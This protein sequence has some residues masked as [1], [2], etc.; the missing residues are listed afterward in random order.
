[1]SGPFQDLANWYWL[2]TP[3][4]YGSPILYSTASNGLVSLTNATYLAWVAAGGTANPW[5]PIGAPTT[6]GL[7][8]LLES[9]GLPATGLTVPTQAQLTA[10]IPSVVSGYLAAQRGYAYTFNIASATYNSTTG[11]LSLTF[12]VA[13]L[14]ASV[15]SMANGQ[16][17]LVAALTLASGSATV[18]GTWPVVSTGSAGTVFNLQAA[19][20]G[21]ATTINSST[22]TMALGVYS[23]SGSVSLSNA[24]SLATWGTANPTSTGSWV[25]NNSGLSWALTGAQLVTL[26]GNIGTYVQTLNAEASVANAEIAAG[27]ITTY[28]EITALAWP[29]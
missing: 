23:D 22:G 3:S 29:T 7:D 20:G 26:Y 21:G 28:A 27:T 25:N 12:S 13:P 6:A 4:G 16:N 1:M 24:A 2:G 18:N 8:A 5:P 15:G 9:V 14:G 19:S 17:M 11:I 10:F